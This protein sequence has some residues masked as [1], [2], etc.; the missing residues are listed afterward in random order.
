MALWYGVLARL[1]APGPFSLDPFQPALLGTAFNSMADHLLA[2]R[3]DID[4][5][6]IGFE[7]FLV[8]GR[9]VSYFGV[10]CAALRVPLV[11][12]PSLSRLDIT[13]PSCL[14]ALGLGLWFQ[15]R[16]LMLVRDS[17]PPS[18][19]RTWLVAALA[20][21]ML[22][23][24]QQVQFLRPSVYQEAIDWAGALAMGFAYLALRGLLSERSFGPVT[25]AGMASFA[26]AAL[27]TRVPVG[28]GLYAA[29]GLLLAA[30]TRPASRALAPSLILVGCA[31]LAGIVNQGRWGNPLVF[32]DFSAY[33]MS[34][35]V[36]PDR[37]VRLAAYGNFHPARVGL[38]LSYYFLPL[39]AL[40]GPDGHLWF[41]AV[42]RR[43]LDSMELP[44][45]SFLLSDPLLLA[46]AGAGIV[47][48]LRARD[49]QALV[50]L[51]GLSLPPLLMLC[52]ISMA[53]RYRMEFYPLL[54]LAALLGLRH[55]CAPRAALP[56]GANAGDGAGKG[57]P[58]RRPGLQPAAR[59]LLI[60]A[61]VSS[62]A[63][64]HGMAALYAVSPWGPAEQ[65]VVAE[66]W[67][68][69]YARWWRNAHP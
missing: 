21:C 60:V 9:T 33:A 59:V 53:H 7:A 40:T 36:F 44:P 66:G 15:L 4:P 22:F 2:G 65:Y 27:L 50:L 49:R 23:G 64:V 58:A 35:D 17:L 54:V 46:L 31:V 5:A 62:V 42:R 30:R 32:A 43:L 29:L 1:L 12:F 63:V 28:V 13:F 3:F 19:R 25:L 20:A 69:Q 56:S 14:A 52:A 47:A 67:M 48:A 68:A 16:A 8:D 55:L 57:A 61:V 11:L 18:P 37:P 10:F 41:D 34:Q 45:G 38:G 26:G 39:W 24:G 6:A 51:A